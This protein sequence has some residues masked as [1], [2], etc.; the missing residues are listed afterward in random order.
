MMDEILLLQS[1]CFR[2]IICYLHAGSRGLGGVVSGSVLARLQL[3]QVVVAHLHVAVVVFETLGEHSRVG[4]A[5][6]GLHVLLLLRHGGHL[7]FNGL[8]RG[9][10]AT[11]EHT[12]DT[13]TQGVTDGRTDGDTSGGQRHLAEQTGTLR[14][15]HGSSGSGGVGRRV[16]GGSSSVGGRVRGGVSRSRLGSAGGRSRSSLSGHGCCSLWLKDGGN[17]RISHVFYI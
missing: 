1:F 2:Y 9:Q 13:G 17:E 11:T 12:G 7:L 5:S 4:V 6:S 10:R 15:L 3:L 8:G 14:G 16:S